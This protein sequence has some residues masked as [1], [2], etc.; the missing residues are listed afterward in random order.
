MGSAV[1]RA[2][3]AGAS[4]ILIVELAHGWRFQRVKEADRAEAHAWSLRMEGFGGPAQPSPTI[5]QCLTVA[6]VWPRVHAA[7][8]ATPLA[9]RGVLASRCLFTP[10]R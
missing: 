3:G 10:E 4:D 8:G 7:S 2:V 6:S 9:L 1:K 5:A